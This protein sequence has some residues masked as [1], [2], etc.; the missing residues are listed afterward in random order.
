[1]ENRYWRPYR[2]SEEYQEEDIWNVIKDNREVVGIKID[3]PR[4][5]PTSPL[6]ISRRLP[7]AA[8]MIPRVHKPENH[9]S[10]GLKLVQQHSAPVSI[11]DWPKIYG[12]S[13][14]TKDD[15]KNG[16]N[17]TVDYHEDVE[18]SDDDDDDNVDEHRL[19]PHE[20]LAKKNARSKTSSFSV[21][22]GA[23]RTLKGRDLCKVMAYL[24]VTS[25]AAGAEMLYLAYKG[26]YDVSAFGRDLILSRLLPPSKTPFENLYQSG[27][28]KI[29]ELRPMLIW[30]TACVLTSQVTIVRE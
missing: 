22:E 17:D 6:S 18:E 1:M 14:K 21:C 11:P 24:M 15:R 7:S 16:N 5:A 19:P 20:W 23:G 29:V 8:R 2:R 30:T 4:A 25:G 26:V 10:D 9:D 27:I 12:K 28:S 13:P 3:E